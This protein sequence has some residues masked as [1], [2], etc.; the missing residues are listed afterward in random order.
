VFRVVVIG[1]AVVAGLAPIDS[2]LVESWYSTN[3]YLVIQRFLTPVS[4]LVPFALLDVL[5]VGALAATLVVLVRSV[6]L[7]R[8]KKTWKPILLILT[9]LVSSG[10]VIYLLFLAVWGLNYRR[11][12]MS[13]RLVLDRDH[14][15]S[16]AILELGR[17]S[18]A[19]LNLLHQPAHAEGWRTSPWREHAM[20]NA[21][22]SILARLADAAPAVPG[23]LKSSLVG[24]YFRWA[25]VD[26]MMNPFG[27]EAIANPDLLPFE[28]PF[29]AAHEW[30]HLAGYADE[31]EASFV[32][33][34][35][36]I[37][38]AAPA[39]YSGW[40]FLYWQINSEV[41]S[42]DRQHLAL[43]LQDGP[44]QDIAAV[45][46]RVRRG[47]I[48]LLR[49]AGWRVYDQFLKA[50]RVEEGVR[51]YGLVLTLLARARFEDG[52]MPVRR[53]PGSGMRDSR[54]DQP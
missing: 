5:A 49:D 12:P 14:A 44:R 52:W 45:G 28:K 16:Q 8:K 19:Q 50:N 3:I 25:S 23:R 40:L 32:G 54:S 41:G 4:N 36:C 30:A 33:F 47:Q 42:A 37:H 22:D 24:P 15:S 10:A 51:S 13:E 17:M 20:R 2:R 7:A 39:A 11:V 31:S 18:V 1:L 21:Y 27:L 43:A 29:V 48:P 9:R 26:G 6:Q 53:A 34:L 38:A 35:T 46:E